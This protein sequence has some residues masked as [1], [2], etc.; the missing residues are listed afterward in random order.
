MQTIDMVQSET[1]TWETE[2]AARIRRLRY[3]AITLAAVL[4]FYG[5]VFAVLWLHDFK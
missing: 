1:G 2:E 4:L 5:F 3:K